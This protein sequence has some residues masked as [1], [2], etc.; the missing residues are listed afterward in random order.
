MTDGVSLAHDMFFGRKSLQLGP[1]EP[2]SRIR[3]CQTWNNENNL[4]NL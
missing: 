2:G 4:P 1:E 3:F